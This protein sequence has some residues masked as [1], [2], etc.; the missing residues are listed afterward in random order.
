[1]PGD[2]RHGSGVGGRGP[3]RRVRHL[4]PLLILPI[5]LSAADPTASPAVGLIKEL[6]AAGVTWT[7][8]GVWRRGGWVVSTAVLPEGDQLAGIQAGAVAGERLTTAVAAALWP[9]AAERLGERWPGVVSRMRLRLP[10]VELDPAHAR[11]PP[12]TALAVDAAGLD[13]ATLLPPSGEPVAWLAVQAERDPLLAEAALRLSPEDLALRARLLPARLDAAGQPRLAALQ[14]LRPTTA[15]ALDAYAAACIAAGDTTEGA[16]AAR[17]RQAL[18]LAPDR[19][20]AWLCGLGLV[21]PAGAKAQIDDDT[22]AFALGD[23]P[24]LSPDSAA[25]AADWLTLAEDA[26]AGQRPAHALVAA[27]RAIVLGGGEPARAVLARIR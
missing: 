7:Q 9:Q 5:C 11:K 24:T 26:L 6:D 1:M 13:R 4:I 10:A 27:R 18:P 22:L 14:A 8:P 19:W 15:G 3:G 25:T 23:A 16:A 20:T 12:V 17:V 21:R 2:R